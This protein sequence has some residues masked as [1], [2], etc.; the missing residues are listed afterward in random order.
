M[1]LV[2]IN[3]EGLGHVAQEI[4]ALG[5]RAQISRADLG[6]DRDVARAIEE[7]MARF[8]RLDFAHN[9]AGIVLPRTDIHETPVEDFDRL[10]ASNLKGVFLCMKREMQIMRSQGSGVIVNTA[11]AAGL[12]GAPGMAPYV[13]SK[14]GVVGLTRT[15]ALE[16]STYGVRVNAVCPGFLETPLTAGRSQEV[17]AAM[18][19]QQP[20]GRFGSP[21]DIAQAVLWLCSEA[22]HFCNAVVL[23]VDM[24]SAAAVPAITPFDWRSARD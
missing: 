15:G 9:N 21:D 12:V 13:G 14:H 1:A 19:A 23:E 18:R 10:W 3:A 11:S 4:A 8:G 24:G 2:D 5:G 7:I 22:G 20:G 17:V 6:L 16:A